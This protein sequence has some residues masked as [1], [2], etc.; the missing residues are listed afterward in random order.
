MRA[1]R[2]ASCFANRRRGAT[3]ILCAL[4]LFVLHN[5]YSKR[6]YYLYPTMLYTF[7]TGIMGALA[8]YGVNVVL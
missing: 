5:G 7:F 8:A 1:R 6:G 2:G 3:L 4:P